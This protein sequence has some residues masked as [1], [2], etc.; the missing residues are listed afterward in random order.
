L[1]VPYRLFAKQQNDTPPALAPRIGGQNRQT[2]VRHSAPLLAQGRVHGACHHS[3]RYGGVAEHARRSEGRPI[4]EYT[5]RWLRL[6]LDR[7]LRERLGASQADRLLLAME[8]GGAAGQMM[9]RQTT[10]ER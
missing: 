6:A 5:D 1:E 8:S 10:C 2:P 3:G 4:T 7:Q 9:Q